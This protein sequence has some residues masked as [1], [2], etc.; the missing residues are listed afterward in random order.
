MYVSCHEF[1]GLVL[2]MYLLDLIFLLL[3]KQAVTLCIHF[4]PECD[5]NRQ[6]IVTQTILHQALFLAGPIHDEDEHSQNDGR[7]CF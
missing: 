4:I 3:P 7:E 2:V 5:S 1:H 6:L